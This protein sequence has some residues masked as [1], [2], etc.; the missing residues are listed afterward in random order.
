MKINKFKFV[1]YVPILGFIALVI[2]Y[3]KNGNTLWPMIESIIF[4]IIQIASFSTFLIYII[5]KVS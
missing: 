1:H 2:D 4:C 5:V 3:F